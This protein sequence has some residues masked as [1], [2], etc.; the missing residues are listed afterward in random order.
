MPSSGDP[1]SP[2]LK[3]LL[4]LDFSTLELINHLVR[5]NSRLLVKGYHGFLALGK[6]T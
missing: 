1:A 2:K 5:A 4:I 3:Y 6:T